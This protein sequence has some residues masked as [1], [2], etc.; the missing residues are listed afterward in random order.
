M[1]GMRCVWHKVNTQWKMIL[2]M[3][4]IWEL[5]IHNAKLLLIN[6]SSVSNLIPAGS[7]VWMNFANFWSAGWSMANER[8]SSENQKSPL[9]PVR[10]IHLPWVGDVLGIQLTGS[11]SGAFWSLKG[12]GWDKGEAP[13]DQEKNWVFS[14]TRQNLS[15]Y[16]IPVPPFWITEPQ[17]YLRGGSVLCW[18][19]AFPFL[20]QC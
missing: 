9:A 14:L 10:G 1:P 11:G 3:L 6:S 19:T 16:L 4:F 13:G 8:A 20:P 15:T 2:L 5:I 12:W 7:E 17:S 18:N